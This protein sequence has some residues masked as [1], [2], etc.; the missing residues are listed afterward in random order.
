M[1]VYVPVYV[2]VYV[3]VHVSVCVVACFCFLLYCVFLFNLSLL[4][5]SRFINPRLDA[6]GVFFV[7]SVN[8]FL[9]CRG[10]KRCASL[11]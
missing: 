1:C 3:Y 9:V 5:K 2:Y 7:S 11:R 10:L 8:L 4:F 6:A